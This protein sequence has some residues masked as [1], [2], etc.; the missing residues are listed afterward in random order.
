MI[1][2]PMKFLIQQRTT[3]AEQS[4]KLATAN[5]LIAEQSKKLTAT[6]VLIAEQSKKLTATNE[7]T[8]T[9]TA[10]VHYRECIKWISENEPQT[11]E[12]IY[13]YHRR[14]GKAKTFSHN[15][16]K[17]FEIFVNYYR[18]DVFKGSSKN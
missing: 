6:E 18:G 9:I 14:Y 7:L 1:E 8:A 13:S 5:E 2:N 10:S 12:T 15:E 4:K 11:D 16:I 17:I 3:I